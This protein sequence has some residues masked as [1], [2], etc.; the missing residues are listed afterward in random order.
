[1]NTMN[2]HKIVHMIGD[3]E[4]IVWGEEMRKLAEAVQSHFGVNFEFLDVDLSLENRTKT[5]GQIVTDAAELV[6][7][8]RFGIKDATITLEEDDSRPG[9]RKSPNG[10]LRKGI[11]SDQAPNTLIF[12]QSKPLPGVPSPV[13]NKGYDQYS[14]GIVRQGA[15]GFYNARIRYQNRDGQSNPS[16]FNEDQVVVTETVPRSQHRAAAMYSFLHAHN[17]GN[18]QVVGGPKYTIHDGDGAFQREIRRARDIFSGIDVNE[19]DGK[20]ILYEVDDLDRYRQSIAEERAK[21]GLTQV[22][23]EALVK[24]NELLIDALYTWF[25]AKGPARLNSNIIVPANNRDGDCLSD[26]VAPLYSSIA[27]MTSEIFAV[28]ENSKPTAIIAEAPHGTAPD[29]R[30]QNIGNPLA[31]F[32]ALST[33]MQR[34]SEQ[35]HAERS[36]VAQNYLEVSNAI[37]NACFQAIAEGKKTG[38]LGGNLTTTD[39]TKAVID[40]LG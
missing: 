7:L 13:P 28:D 3:E 5:G 29:I 31:M 39:F 18:T 24:Y 19:L 16:I 14:T 33:I 20:G 11:Q 4:A 1:M 2:R 26:L 17:Q 35:E 30:G 34:I 27:G 6:K 10:Q 32:L 23:Q 38:D 9:I 8:H 21:L 37:K 22:S 25:I 15:G 40:R 12:R 36:E